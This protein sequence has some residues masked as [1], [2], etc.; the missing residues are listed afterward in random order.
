MRKIYVN[1]PTLVR[2][3]TQGSI[4]NNGIATKYKS[5]ISGIIITAR[6]D[7]SHEAKVEYVYY[8]PIVGL[9]D[10]YD[11]DGKSCLLNKDILANQ[12]K[13]MQSCT[14]NHIPFQQMGRDQLIQMSTSIEDIQRR[15][16]F[17]SLVERYFYLKSISVEDYKPSNNNIETLVNNL[18][19]NKYLDYQLIECWEDPSQLK[20]ILLRD[21]KRIEY[22]IAINLS[23]GV[24]ENN[25]DSKENNDLEYSE[26]N[27][28]L[29]IIKAEMASPYVEFVLQRFAQNFSRIGLEDMNEE[30]RN[31]MKII[32]NQ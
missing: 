29:Y 26:T 24:E 10:W 14:Q 11:I 15:N 32:I 19:E 3:L 8:L 21:L 17:I 12:K 13:L 31:N 22:K 20:V 4:F 2:P 16:A 9:K 27:N 18:F 5:S 25:I 30:K 28:N 1:R 6:C 23:G 7:L